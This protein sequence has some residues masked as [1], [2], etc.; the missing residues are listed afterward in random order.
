MRIDPRELPMPMQE[1][2][3]EKILAQMPAPNPVAEEIK[4]IKVRVR[5]LRFRTAATRW[6]YLRLRDLVKDDIIYDLVL[7]ID[8][9]D[10][11]VHSFAYMVTE[12]AM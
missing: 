1:Q 5:R 6:R 8:P 7:S 4:P 3:A 12:E 2:L 11:C 9:K 10:G